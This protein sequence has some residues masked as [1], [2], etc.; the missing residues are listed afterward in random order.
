MAPHRPPPR[1]RVRPP[2]TPDTD[3]PPAAANPAS[4]DVTL[5]SQNA[6]TGS[7]GPAGGS[8]NATASDGT[9][10]TLVVPEGALFGP[11]DI[12]MTPMASVG[13]EFDDSLLGGVTLE[14][15]GLYFAGLVT[16]EVAGD[17]IDAG[18]LGASADGGEDL[19]LIPFDSRRAARC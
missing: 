17:G 6:V 15:S 4:I 1:R 12:T 9:R 16:L 2:S 7:I 19:H 18:S 13:D 5:E 10:F 8:L 11:V 14:P 3:A